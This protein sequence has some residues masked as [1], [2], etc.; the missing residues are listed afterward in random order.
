MTIIVVS[1]F[2]RNRVSVAG[3]TYD[4]V[5]VVGFAR[6]QVRPI[7]E[8]SS[9]LV[10]SATDLAFSNFANSSFTANDSATTGFAGST[11]P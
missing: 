6:D 8:S 3:F 2:G 9:S 4:R 7:A 10:S 5:S 1:G 11:S